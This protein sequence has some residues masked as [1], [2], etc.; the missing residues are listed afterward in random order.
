MIPTRILS[1][2][3]KIG[4]GQKR[5]Q[6][7]ETDAGTMPLSEAAALTG[8]TQNVLYHRLFNAKRTNWRSECIFDKEI[9]KVRNWEP[10]EDFTPSEERGQNL[11]DR[12]THRRELNTIRQGTW[13]RRDNV[14]SRY[15]MEQTVKHLPARDRDYNDALKFNRAVCR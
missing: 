4:A 11:P 3:W 8:L 6:M 13:E 9:P 1:P 14:W 12:K 10:G 2:P 15:R 5:Q 7:L